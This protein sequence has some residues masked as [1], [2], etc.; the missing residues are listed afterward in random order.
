L[1][2]PKNKENIILEAAVRVFLEKGFSATTIQDV[3]SAAGIAKGTIYDYFKDKDE[4]FIAAFKYQKCQAKEEIVE[5]LKQHDNFL[6]KVNAMLDF[7]IQSK[8]FFPK[9]MEIVRNAVP[10]LKESALAGLPHPSAMHQDGIE[11]W[12]EII[13]L[14]IQEGKIP[15]VDVAFMATCAFFLT[16]SFDHF[17]FDHDP[18]HYQQEKE[19]FLDFLFHGMRLKA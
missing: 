12:S 2:R 7:P 13:Q 16:I 9:W 14:G 6:D 4:L 19:M 10:V 18:L 17:I 11:V 8:G 15:E 3:A 1:A 5:I